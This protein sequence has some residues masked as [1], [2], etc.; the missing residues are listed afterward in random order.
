M[1]HF[2]HPHQTHK[3]VFYKE[4][5][6]LLQ[7]RCHPQYH[8]PTE[9]PPISMIFRPPHIPH[10]NP[11]LFFLGPEDLFGLEHHIPESISLISLKIFCALDDRNFFPNSQKREGGKRGKWIGIFS[12]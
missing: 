7:M 12:L 9:H 4:C 8:S 5:K 6:K 2:R 10:H 1:L 3:Q 11:D